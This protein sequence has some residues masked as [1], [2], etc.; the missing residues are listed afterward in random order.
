MLR[1]ATGITG[2]PTLEIVTDVRSTLPKSL[3]P[4]KFDRSITRF[5]AVM[6]SKKC[7]CFYERQFTICTEHY[8]CSLLEMLRERA[9][10]I[11]SAASHAE[12]D[13]HCERAACVTTSIFCMYAEKTILRP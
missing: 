9:C 6:F 1:S 5:P 3:M 8:D 11:N 10:L 2:S 13:S 12:S 7:P 4:V